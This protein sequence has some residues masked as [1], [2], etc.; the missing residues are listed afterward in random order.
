MVFEYEMNR[1]EEMQNYHLAEARIEEI[2]GIDLATFPMS[3]VPA[4]A[5]PTLELTK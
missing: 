1:H 4:V 3:P 5:E 2:S